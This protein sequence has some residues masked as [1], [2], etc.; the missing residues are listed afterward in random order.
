MFTVEVERLSY[1]YREG[2]EVLKD[3]SFKVERGEIVG[4]VGP[5]GAGKSTLLKILSGS[6]KDYG[7]SA[8]I[9]GLEVKNF[10]EW[11]R[12]GYAPQRISVDSALP[13]TPR[14]LFKSARAD[15]S[16]VSAIF[17]MEGFL[18]KPFNQL[19]GGQQ[20]IV[21]VALALACAQDLLI[22]DE[23]TVGLDVHVKRHLM[24][25]VRTVAS[26]GTTV[27]I[28]SHEIGLLLKEC[29]KILG[30]DK[31]VVFFGPPEESISALEEI[32]WIPS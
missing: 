13:I 7:G 1:S 6:L 3:V 31:E 16:Q 18:D 26:E 28:A 17:H 11:R 19:S 12:V 14:E 22:L 20:Q 8:K 15:L 29:D 9:L 5:N 2:E 23:P 21:L 25:T 4:I 27:L 10:N 30:L 24:D 32:L